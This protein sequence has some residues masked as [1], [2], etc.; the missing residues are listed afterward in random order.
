M[1]LRRFS[2]RVFFGICSYIYIYIYIYSAPR[3]Q[4]GTN[5]SH[6]RRWTVCGALW[7]SGVL[8]GSSGELWGALGC[9]GELCIYIY[10]LRPRRREL[11]YIYIYIY[12]YLAVQKRMTGTRLRS[13]KVVPP[14]ICQKVDLLS[15]IVY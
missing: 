8:W 4:V 7:R 12:I 14:T 2:G 13:L 11:I 10:I 1:F 3:P 15:N 5:C 9:S 6:F